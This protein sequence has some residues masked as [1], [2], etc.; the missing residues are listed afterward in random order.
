MSDSKGA[1]ISNR[2]PERDAFVVS[3]R[4]AGHTLQ[5]IGD[6]L[7]VS[8]ERARQL[9]E[10]QGVT[11]ASV[12][13]KVDP[14]AVLRFA[15]SRECRSFSDIKRHFG[16]DGVQERKALRALGVGRALRRLFRL[17]HRAAM[18]QQI[19]SQL[20]TFVEREGR[21]PTTLEL[22]NHRRPDL[23]SWMTA[24]RLFGSLEAAYE[25]AGLRYVRR[26]VGYP[27][28]MKPRKG[29]L[30]SGFCRNGHAWTPDNTATYTRPDGTE[31]HVCRACQRS[32][33]RQSRVRAKR[34]P[35]NI[36]AL[37]TPLP[38]DPHA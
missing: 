13:A 7:G 4:Q 16:T 22:T 31:V 17:R 24:T 23:P 21:N 3:L 29:T 30:A 19:V 5:E 33:R 8:R 28:H 14:L 34:S 37:P 6:M 2:S 9:L 27:S 12:A 35:R 18:Q 36:A 20:R 38:R 10:R 25:A 1:I 11:K 32:A 26:P 15:R